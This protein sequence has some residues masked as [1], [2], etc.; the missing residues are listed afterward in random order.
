MGNWTNFS[1]I[2]KNSLKQIEFWGVN[3]FKRKKALLFTLIELL[4]VI[5]II[6]ILAAMLMPALQKARDT[7]RT[8]QCLNNIASI[9]KAGLLYSDDN[10]GFYPML[11]N[12]GSSGT[13]SKHLLRGTAKEG[14]LSV[15]LGTDEVAPL[16]GWYQSARAGFH[17]SKLACPAVNGRRRFETNTGGDY[18]RYGIGESMEISRCPGDRNTR[19]VV[20]RIKQPSRSLFFS[21]GAMARVGH[22]TDSACAYPV[23]PHKGGVDPADLNSLPVGLPGSLNIVMLDGHGKTTEFKSLPLENDGLNTIFWYP[24]TGTQN[25]SL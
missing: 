4:V 16:G 13:A 9:G 5:A 15:Y 8:T 12:A 14:K 17:V 11:F 1:Q 18:N 6:A 7:A 21:E 20:S 3:K 2:S 24:D 19:I 25:W 23:A 22:K 10:R